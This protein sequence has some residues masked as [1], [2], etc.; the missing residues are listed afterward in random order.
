MLKRPNLATIPYGHQSISEE[1]IQAVVDVL[2]SEW[3]TQGPMVSRF[4]DALR[5]YCGAKHAV[6]VSNG[7]AALHLA[8][9]AVGLGPGDSLWTSPNTFVASANCALYC[10]AEIDFVDID[11]RTYNLSIEAL[12]QKLHTAEHDGCLPKVLVPV[13]FAGQSC[14]MLRIRALSERYGFY[15]IEDAC[16]ALGGSYNGARVGSCGYSD[17]TVF[18]FH[19]AKTI[20]TGEGGMVLTNDERLSRRLLMLRSHGISKDK[21]EV[22]GS[23]EGGWCYRQIELGYNYRMS[24]LQAALGLSQLHCIEMFVKRR[25][26]LAGR[27]D[28]ALAGLQLDTQSQPSGCYSARHLYP[29]SLRGGAALRHHVYDR[30][31]AEG[32]HC[33]VHYIPVHTQPFYRERG[34]LPG[35]FPAAEAYY[36]GALSLPLFYDLSDVQ[37]DRVIQA[38][39]SSL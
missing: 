29:I 14:D 13:H 30:L 17:L 19:P 36:C 27:Y 8:C 18:S 39:W 31:H 38:L 3:L 21:A 10:G 35:Q 25:H 4:E 15:V 24:D 34:F 23:D 7:T 26:E 11:P 16:H 6:A 1:D 28:N 22:G 37:Q 33:Q 5:E 20:T 12:E 9:L 2:R 32:I